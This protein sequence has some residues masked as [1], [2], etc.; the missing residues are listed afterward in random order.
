M[1]F[2]QIEKCIVAAVSV[3]GN[4]SET[5]GLEKK[6]DNYFIQDINE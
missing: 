5:G 4:I 1:W 2:S 3:Q 6:E